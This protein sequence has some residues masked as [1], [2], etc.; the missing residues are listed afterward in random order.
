MSFRQTAEEKLIVDD[1]TKPSTP[2][3]P[4]VEDPVSPLG[5]G[6]KVA[7]F[8]LDPGIANRSQG[9]TAPGKVIIDWPLPTPTPTP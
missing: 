3:A 6:V 2:Y 9:V 5:Y 1:W 7:G 8:V 4:V